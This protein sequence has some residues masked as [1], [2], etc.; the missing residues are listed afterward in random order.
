MNSLQRVRAV[1]RGDLP[2][3]VPVCLHNFMMAAREAAIP[4]ESIALIP[5]PSHVRT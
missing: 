5:K 3:R 4:M 2:D 1:L